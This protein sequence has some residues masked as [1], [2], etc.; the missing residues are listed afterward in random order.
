MRRI[1][2]KIA[3]GE[4]KS[5]ADYEKLGDIS[6]LVNPGQVDTLVEGRLGFD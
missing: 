3:N 2:R 4:V 1:L 6:T 5:K